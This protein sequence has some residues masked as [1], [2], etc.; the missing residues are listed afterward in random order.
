ME[1]IKLSSLNKSHQEKF[2]IGNVLDLEEKYQKILWSIFSSNGFINNLLNIE[3][4]IQRN[5][6]YL[7][8]NYDIKNKLKIPAERL[9]RFYIYNPFLNNGLNVLNIFPSPIS[10]DIA[11][12]TTDA[13]I[14]I[15][16]KTLDIDGNSGDIGNLQYLPNQSSFDHKNVGTHPKYTNS[17]IKVDS[18][19]PRFFENKP[20]LTY[21]LTIVYEDNQKSNKFV[22]SR[23]S[24]YQT[25]HLI[26]LPNGA[27]SPLFNY[28]L[29]DN[30]KTYSYFNALNGFKPILLRSSTSPSANVETASMFSN[31]TDYSVFQM[32]SK[33]AVLDLKRLHPNYGTNVTW[34]PVSRKQGSI[35][36]FFLEAINSGNT[37]RINETKLENRYN[38]KDILWKGLNKLTIK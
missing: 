20:V 2:I 3:K 35:N 31:N 4:E 18:K 5:Y 38:S 1:Q 26:N 22:I 32:A 16:V 28:E 7:T 36:R 25:I 13:V 34:V 23:D 11:F 21:F 17:G 33:T 9:A 37:N 15:D 19:L 8:T 29:I 14:N 6:N 12:I 10:G 24:S 27:I 30:F